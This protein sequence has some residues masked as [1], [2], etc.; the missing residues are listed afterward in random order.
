MEF[1]DVLQQRRSIRTYKTDHPISD[2]ELRALFELVRLSPSASN[3]QHWRFVVIR[4]PDAKTQLRAAAFG[5]EQIETSSA[6]IVVIG[7]L[8]AHRDAPRIYADTSK[9]VQQAVLPSIEKFYGDNAPLQRDEAVRSASF[10]AMSLMLAA[11]DMGFATGP[12][13]GFD[14]A[15]VSEL[16][17]LDADHIPVMLIVIGRQQGDIRPRSMRL[18]VSEIVKCEKLNGRSLR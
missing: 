18:P 3:L 4:A 14:P 11:Q 13:I 10:A 9:Q 8:D 1:A 16:I 5:Q 15:A 12:M 2:A 17:E 7:K 6:T